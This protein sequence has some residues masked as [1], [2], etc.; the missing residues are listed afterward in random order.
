MYNAIWHKLFLTIR[1]KF[2]SVIVLDAQCLWEKRLL[3]EKFIFVC[4]I[5]YFEL[6]ILTYVALVA[7]IYSLHSATLLADVTEYYYKML[8]YIYLQ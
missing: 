8:K 4:C 6:P 5:K 7:K 1:F 2:L 3:Y